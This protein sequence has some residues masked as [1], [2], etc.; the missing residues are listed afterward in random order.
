MANECFYC[1]VS[2]DVEEMRPYGPNMES[3]CFPCAMKPENKAVTDA[4]FRKTIDS[5]GDTVILTNNGPVPFK[6][7]NKLS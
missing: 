5:C 6:P 4:M 1:G 7:A 2:S 3:V